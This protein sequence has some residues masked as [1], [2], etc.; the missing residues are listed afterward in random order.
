[1]GD[2]V[3]IS[4]FWMFTVVIFYTYAG[5]PFVL[6]LVS[7]FMKK[8]VNKGAY[9]PGVSV[10]LSAFNEE[11]AIGEKLE[12]LL[13]LNYPQHKL[14]ILVGS[15]GAFDKTD[16][17]VTRCKS[18]QIRFF[19]FVRNLGKPQVLNALAEEARGSVL[20]FTDARQELNPDAIG[21]LTG[22]NSFGK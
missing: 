19:R 5:Y 9:E 4:L 12:N 20:V 3:M 15:D 10:I 18:S 1:M 6:W 11:K 14:E 13:R 7:C 22:M 2:T 16:E 21:L 17:I 8:R